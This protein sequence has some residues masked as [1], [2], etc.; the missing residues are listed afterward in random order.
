MRAGGGLDERQKPSERLPARPDVVAAGV[1]TSLPVIEGYARPGGDLRSIFGPK[2]QSAFTARP[3]HELAAMDEDART[4]TGLGLRLEQRLMQAAEDLLAHEGRR[5]MSMTFPGA[6]PPMFIVIG[7]TPQ[8]SELLAAANRD[9][10]SE[11]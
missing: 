11:E 10:R 2:K 8:L 9:L 3:P 1:P 7:E 5:V 4:H 6:V